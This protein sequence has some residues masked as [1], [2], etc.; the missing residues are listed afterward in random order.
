MSYRNYPQDPTSVIYQHYYNKNTKQT[1]SLVQQKHLK[2]QDGFFNGEHK[3]MTMSEALS[4]LNSY[5]DPSDPDTDGDNVIHAYQTAERIRKDYPNMEWFQVL[6]LIHDVGKILFTADEPDF[7]VVGDTFPLGCQYRKECVYSDFFIDNPEQY[8]TLGIYK[9]KCGLD[10]LIM[11]YGHDEYLYNVLIDNNS[12]LPNLA[13]RIIRY[14]SFYPLHSYGAYTEF[15][16]SDDMELV[17]WLQKFSDYDLY[18]KHDEFV[19]TDNIKQYY[20]NLLKKYF[21]NPLIW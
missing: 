8:T 14:H 12:I 2:Y 19:L 11:T 20:E 5:K 10:N 16:D 21:P 4:Q 7:C 18:T 3:I 13:H 15:L 9:E 17:P 1:L 6:G